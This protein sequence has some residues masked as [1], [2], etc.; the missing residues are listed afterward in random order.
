MS[1]AR[2]TPAQK[3]RGLARI[4]RST[5]VFSAVINP[6]P[7]PIP[8]YAA[9]PRIGDFVSPLVQIATCM[10]IQK[11]QIEPGPVNDGPCI[12]RDTAEGG[13]HTTASV[14]DGAGNIGAR[15]VCVT[16]FP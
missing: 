11:G 2:T 13:F 4:I 10:P 8:V 3:P 14:D 15:S 16:S 7:A 9:A 5:A 12:M 1:I 6:S